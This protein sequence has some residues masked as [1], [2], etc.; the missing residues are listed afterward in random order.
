MGDVMPAK[1]SQSRSGLR[2][3]SVALMVGLTASFAVQQAVIVRKGYEIYLASSGYG[4]KSWHLWEFVTYQV[5]HTGLAQLIVNLLG[6]W[7][8]GRAA[9][10]HLGGRRFLL[11]YFGAGAVGAMLQGGVALAGFV[12]PESIE[13]VAAFLRDRCGGMYAGSSVGL[14]G[15]LAACCWS[16]PEPELPLLSRFPIK[17]AAWW[18]FALALAIGFTAF[19]FLH[20]TET[21][22]DLAYFAHLAHLPA[23]AENALAD[24][25]GCT[26]ELPHLAHLGALLAGRVLAPA[27]PVE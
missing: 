5:L 26:L 10:A 17:L 24:Y 13:S 1:E 12:L 7:F 27:A 19:S 23:A 25:L 14:L 11:V 8:L 18:W 6:L 20:R 4:V 3:F 9:E 15:V 2:S 21:R 22:F 16:K